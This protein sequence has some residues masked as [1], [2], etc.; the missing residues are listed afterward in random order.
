MNSSDPDYLRQILSDLVEDCCIVE[1]FKLQQI[2]NVG[3]E[4]LES[5]IAGKAEVLE[6][7][8]GYIVAVPDSVFLVHEWRV[9][10]RSQGNSCLV[11]K[12]SF[13]GNQIFAHDDKCKIETAD[14][15][16]VREFA[17]EKSIDQLSGQKRPLE[18]SIKF[19]GTG[20]H[21]SGRG[22]KK[23]S[24]TLGEFVTN[25]KV[26]QHHQP[27]VEELR[28]EVRDEADRVDP[29]FEGSSFNEVISQSAISTSDSNPLLPASSMNIRGVM[30]YT[31]NDRFR[32]VKIH[33][34]HFTSH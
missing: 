8:V 3:S 28:R 25:N 1:S 5:T 13:T 27:D 4:Q 18:N 6:Y 14:S 26:Q 21:Q 10:E 23:K 32:I 31:L 16:D 15:G 24:K 11:F 20:S 19:K 9:F 7:F 2:G 29:K 30:R 33:C 22:G 12:F 17:D 34:V